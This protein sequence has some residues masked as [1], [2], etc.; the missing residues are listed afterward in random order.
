MGWLLALIQFSKNKQLHRRPLLGW[1]RISYVKALYKPFCSDPSL[2]FTGRLEEYKETTSIQYINTN[3]RLYD[4]QLSQILAFTSTTSLISPEAS[5]RFCKAMR[6]KR[7]SYL[8]PGPEI[9]RCA[10]PLETWASVKAS[11]LIIIQGDL[12]TR[13]TTKDIATDVIDL[14]LKAK[15]P[16]IWALNSHKLS[17][18]RESIAIEILKQFVSQALQIN[19][20][21]HDER[22]ASLTAAR[23]QRAR[24]EEEW[25][26][27]LGSVIAG[28]PRLFIIVDVEIFGPQSEDALV[29]PVA[30]LLLFQKLALRKVDTRLKVVL[31]SY[32]TNLRVPVNNKEHISVVSLR[33]KDIGTS[34]SALTRPLQSARSPRKGTGLNPLSRQLVSI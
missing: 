34:R 16:V 14:V 29:W 5:L 32:R 2:T 8:R 18:F 23:F 1:N 17:E 13:D 19:T 24:T 21:L 31:A 28:L 22:S 3:Q 30:F 12:N 4:L 10:G 20:A 26:D 33:K 15:I 9:Q 7:R 11:S 6:K 27:L 25:F